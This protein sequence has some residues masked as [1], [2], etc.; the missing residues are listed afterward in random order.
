[1]PLYNTA[2]TANAL[3]V[4]QKW[5][6][7]LLSHNKLPGVQQDRQG[8]QRKV[9]LEAVMTISIAKTLMDNAGLATPAALGLAERLVASPNGIVAISNDL[10]ISIN[11]ST[12]R[13]TTLDQLSHAIEFTPLP[14][15]GRPPSTGL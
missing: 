5:I 9:S 14:T 15:R 7:N 4:A 1:M 11:L 10:T 12:V 8:V 6:D 13:Q 2:S 3:N